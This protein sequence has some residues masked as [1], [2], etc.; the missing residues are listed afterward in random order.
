MGY[1]YQRN[2]FWRITVCKNSKRTDI[3]LGPDHIKAKLIKASI[4][5]AV[6]DD[7]F[8]QNLVNTLVEMGILK[9]GGPGVA[10]NS[11]VSWEDAKKK[12]FQYFA[13]V[14]KAKMTILKYQRV[15]KS[16][17]VVLNPASPSDISTVKADQ[18]VET[19]LN[20]Q[21]KNDRSG[22]KLLSASGVNTMVRTAKSA[23]QKFLRWRYASENPFANCEMPQVGFSLPR[24]LTSEEI[25]KML[26]ASNA[27]LKRVI[28]ILVNS[29]MRPNEL[30]HL[31]WKRVVLGKNPY[32]HIKKDGGWTPKAHTE[33]MIPISEALKAALGKPG[34]PDELV[35]GK[36][37]KG[38]LINKNWLDRTFKRMIKRSGLVG[39]R[40]TVYCCRDTYA[41]NLALQGFEAHV[42][43]SR[44]GHRNISTSMRYV[45]M[46]RLN[47]Q[48]VNNGNQKKGGESI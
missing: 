17:E 3:N 13:N 11:A 7:R 12:L 35:A 22:T 6:Q 39:K 20:T 16:L 18:W 47:A 48:S 25:A 31:T 19:L 46:A 24:P 29:G 1:M 14:R 44:L 21:N 26:A 9:K 2:G 40:I 38:F 4:E 45:S 8:Q 33:R 28:E 37:A 10:A 42:I 36:N 23:Y 41:T 5:Q 32:I 30:Y 27:P 34:L 15:F 43:A